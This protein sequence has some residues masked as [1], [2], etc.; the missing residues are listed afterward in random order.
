MTRF[1]FV[2]WW[3]QVLHAIAEWIDN[4]VVSPISSKLTWYRVELIDKYC[5][6]ERC[7]KRDADNPGWR[8][9]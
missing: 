6:C 5:Q 3:V 1:E 8:P 2:P 9:K 4:I 7:R